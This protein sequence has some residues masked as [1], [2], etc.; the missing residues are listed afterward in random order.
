MYWI[1]VWIVCTGY[2]TGFYVLDTGLDFMYWIRF[3]ILCT[4]YGT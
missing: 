1:R 3:R 4:E 2:G